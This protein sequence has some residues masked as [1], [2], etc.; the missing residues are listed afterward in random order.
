[1]RRATPRAWVT[2]SHD[3]AVT[4]ADTLDEMARIVHDQRHGL[5]ALAEHVDA[6]D[7]IAV[8]VWLGR[9]RVRACVPTHDQLALDGWLDPDHPEVDLDTRPGP[10]RVKVLQAHLDP[11]KHLVV[12]ARRPGLWGCRLTVR[13]RRDTSTSS[14]G[15]PSYA[16]RTNEEVT[17]RAHDDAPGVGVHLSVDELAGLALH[18]LD[19]PWHY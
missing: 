12:A 18:P 17:V 15:S 7:I 11:A 9:M 13:A 16:L 2:G 19:V 14:A 6:A 4:G 8:R 10:G 5:P 1:M 3:L